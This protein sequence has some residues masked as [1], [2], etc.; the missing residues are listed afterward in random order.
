MDP[1][2]L[3]D[4]LAIDTDTLIEALWIKI[5]SYIQQEYENE[6]EDDCEA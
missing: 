3:V 5:E 6:N 2:D 4:E 1:D